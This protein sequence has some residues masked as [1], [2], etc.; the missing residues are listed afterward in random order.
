MAVRVPVPDGS[1]VDLV[2]ETREQVSAEAINAAL[3]A[4][5]EGPLARVL[6]YS[7]DE[8]V[9]SDIVG[10][11]ESSIVDALSTSVQGGNLLKVLTWYDNEW[12]YSN[13]LCDLAAKLGNLDE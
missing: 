3:K 7:S 11:P 2:L 12:G 1:L 13:R 4:A 8:I 6:G 9:S 10:R 5:S